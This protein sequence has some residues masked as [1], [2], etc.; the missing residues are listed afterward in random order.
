MQSKKSDWHGIHVGSVNLD[1][2]DNIQLPAPEPDGRI[3]TL[4][5]MGM[6]TVNI[7]GISEDFVKFAAKCDKPILD[8]GCAYGETSIGAIK[9]GAKVVIASDIDERFLNVI[10]KDKRLSNED[11]QRLFYKLGKLPND[12]DFPESSLSAIH[13]ARVLHFFHPDEVEKLFE[14][15]RK[16]LEPNG[17]LFILTASPYHYAIPG[18]GKIYEERYNQGIEWPGEVNDF[19]FNSGQQFANKTPSYLHEIDPRVLFRVATKHGFLIQKLELFGGEN[20]NDYTG[21][22]F[23][24]RK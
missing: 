13:M 20:E 10:A 21:G 7:I 11:R 17:R 9:A 6:A 1:E 23:I 4:S 18:F 12:I 19:T 22:I 2:L 8:A 24:N 5:N 14:N 3:L 16:W 15:A